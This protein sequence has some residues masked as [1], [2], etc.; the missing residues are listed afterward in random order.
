MLPPGVYFP[1]WLY[2]WTKWD[3]MKVPNWI[4]WL[5]KMKWIWPFASPNINSTLIKFYNFNMQWPR[6]HIAH[7]RFVHKRESILEIFYSIEIQKSYPDSL[8][9]I[10]WDWCS[11]FWF[12]PKNYKCYDNFNNH[13]N[14]RKMHKN[15][16]L[17]K[18]WLTHVAEILLVKYKTALFDMESH[19]FFSREE[20]PTAM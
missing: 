16:L 2:N 11:N 1:L 13:I 6:P 15:N 8:F 10:W 3:K 17:K 9:T 5:A 12:C 4:P 7:Y 14:V 20:V 18:I 19:F